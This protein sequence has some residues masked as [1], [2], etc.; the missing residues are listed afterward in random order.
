MNGPLVDRLARRLAARHSRRQVLEVAGKGSVVGLGATLIAPNIGAGILGTLPAF[1][2]QGQETTVTIVDFAFEPNAIEVNVGD[3]VT[4]TNTGNAPHTAT[5]DDGTFDSGTLNNGGT[6]SHTFA[7][8]GTVAYH[9][10]LHPDMTGTIV[11]AEVTAPAPYTRPNLHSPEADLESYALA[12]TNMKALGDDDPRSWMYQANIHGTLLDQSNWLELFYTCEHRSDFFWPWHRM[13]LYWFEQIVRDQSGNPDWALPYWDY[14]DPTHQY[15]PEPFRDPDNPLFV[16]E[17]SRAVN[18]RD[19]NSPG[20]DEPMFDYCPGLRQVE[21][22]AWNRPL[23]RPPAPSPG[24]ALTLETEVHDQIH[25]WVGGRMADGTPGLMS[26]VET[27][28]QDP[29]FW[30]H[31]ANMDRLWASWRAITQGG[32]SRQ[33][34]TD[35]IW[36]DTPHEFF[37]QTGVT[38]NPPWQVKQVTDTTID[39]LGYQYEA[40]ADNAWFETNCQPSIPIPGQDEAGG[41]T[42]SATPVAL[43]EVGTYA[44]EEG[45]D[46]GL[47]PV[48]VPI[49][50]ELPEAGGSLISLGG[51]MVVLTLDGIE[52]AGIPAVSVEVYIN[53][54]PDQEPNFRTP[55][56]V[57]V[58][59]LFAL[60]T[61][62]HAEHG[63]SQSFDISQNLAALE[64]SGEWA[65]ELDVRFVSKDLDPSSLDEAGVGTPEAMG[66]PWVTIESISVS[67]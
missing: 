17:S 30:L 8:A 66:G 7:T 10:E 52:S 16:A 60:G 22:G 25:G 55:Y 12:V 50:L 54:P 62:P 38:I 27:A 35:P 24:A 32:V 53:V 65:G 43:M 28:A 23:D 64:A 18:S 34:P 61:G 33:D 26:I 45:I 20:I 11:I 13:E 63:S 5:A 14:S 67:V 56:F 58:I 4:W 36:G 42:P 15:L 48:D 41:A 46:I 31:H 29:V 3:T 2:R 47:D 51:G 40:L 44:P 6:F 37:D 1:A 21:F 59:G 39:P 49:P 19:K 57:G 9:C